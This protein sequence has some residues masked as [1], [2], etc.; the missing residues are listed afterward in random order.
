MSVNFDR[1]YSVMMPE[2]SEIQGLLD[3]C[4][5]SLTKKTCMTSSPHRFISAALSRSAE[6]G[7]LNLTSAQNRSDY[8]TPPGA[9]STSESTCA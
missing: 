6:M 2:P 3:N 4:Q 9:L 7:Y 1:V 5:S 8:S